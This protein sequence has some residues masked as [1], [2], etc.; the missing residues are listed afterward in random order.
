MSKSPFQIPRECEPQRCTINRKEYD[1]TYSAH[2]TW[3]VILVCKTLVYFQKRR[4]KI[5]DKLRILQE[6]IPNGNKVRNLAT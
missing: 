6:L 4:V 2:Y 3:W 1:F 5:N